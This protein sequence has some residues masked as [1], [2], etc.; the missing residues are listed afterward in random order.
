[1]DKYQQ[2][3]LQTEYLTPPLMFFLTDIA[4]GINF[5]G[6]SILKCFSINLLV[7]CVCVSLNVQVKAFQLVDYLEQKKTEGYTIIGVEQ[8]AKS[9]DLTEYRFPEKSLLLLG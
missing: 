7:G 9:C 4:F 2:K 8:T 5:K 6:Y 3:G 1:M